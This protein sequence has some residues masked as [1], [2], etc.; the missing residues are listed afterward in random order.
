[1]DELNTPDTQLELLR[2]IHG[3][4]NSLNTATAII[5]ALLLVLIWRIW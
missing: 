3:S 5:A 4:L 2:K 1:M